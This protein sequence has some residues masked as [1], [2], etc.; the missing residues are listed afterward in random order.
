MQKNF[1]E[2]EIEKDQTLAEHDPLMIE[3]SLDTTDVIIGIHLPPENNA[4][5]RNRYTKGLDI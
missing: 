4:E 5:V 2:E 3:T 1:A